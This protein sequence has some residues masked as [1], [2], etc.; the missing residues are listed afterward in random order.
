MTTFQSIG[1]VNQLDTLH[2][3]QNGLKISFLEIECN[4]NINDIHEKKI[5][6]TIINSNEYAVNVAFDPLL[7]YSSKDSAQK[8]TAENHQQFK[9]AAKS[10]RIGACTDELPYTLFH[11]FTNGISKAKLIDF[12]IENLTVTPIYSR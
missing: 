8:A 3:E 5:A 11:S 12:K 4:D 7:N 2:F 10:T 9:L 1:Q 6:L